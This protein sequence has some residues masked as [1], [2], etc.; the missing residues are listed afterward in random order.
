MEQIEF[1]YQDCQPMDKVT[2][3][4]IL[5]NLK[6]ENCHLDLDICGTAEK[7]FLVAPPGEFKH[8]WPLLNTLQSNRRQL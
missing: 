6:I 7:A 4:K 5:E 2:D 1:P 3:A 8:F